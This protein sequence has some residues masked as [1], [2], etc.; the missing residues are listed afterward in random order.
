VT[1]LFIGGGSSEEAERA[2]MNA[3]VNKMVLGANRRDLDEVKRGRYLDRLGVRGH[4][5]FGFYVEG[6]GDA[7][8]GSLCNAAVIPSSVV[9]FDADETAESDAELGRA[10]RG[11]LTFEAEPWR[12]TVLPQ[13]FTDAPWTIRSMTAPGAVDLRGRVVARWPAGEATFA[14]ATVEGA[15]E[16]VDTISRHLERSPEV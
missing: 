2:R 12:A 3:A 6:F 15:N 16:A 7:E 5:V 8:V 11:E 1:G 14:F 4:V 10:P 13:D 9:F